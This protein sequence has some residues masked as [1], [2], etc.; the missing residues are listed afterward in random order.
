ML[1][2]IYVGMTGLTGYSRGLRVIA[3]NTTNINTPGFKKS[4]LEF[5]DLFYSNRATGGGNSAYGQLGF[6]L[7]TGATTLSFR[8]GELRQTGNDLDLAIDGQ[9]MFMLRD[10]SGRITY[11]RAGQLEFNSE[12]ILVDRTSGLTVLGFDS[13]GVLGSISID[14]M[15]TR[16]GSATTSVVF[17]GNL[18]SSSTT[19][20]VGNVRVIDSAGGEHVLSARFTNT[21]ATTPGSWNV[22]LLDGTTVVGAAQQIIFASGVP[23]A[24]TSTLNFTYTPPGFTAPM[25]VTLDFS[26]DVTSFAAGTLSTLAMTSQNGFQPGGLTRVSFDASGTLVLT[27]ANGQTTNHGQLAL[28]R[29]DTEDGVVAVGDNQFQAS[30]G[31]GWQTGTAESGSFGAVRGGVVEISNVDLSQ[32]FS[33]LIVMQ[34]GYQASSQIITT[35]NEMLQELFQMKGR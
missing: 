5:K 26:T 4:T 29:F 9:G 21:N 1:E 27:Y 12:G 25:N 10:P 16:A 14:G 18:S 3:N 19:Q 28:A 32:E 20:T 23:T 8:Q 22:E 6:G 7:N 33:D 2:S 30:S 13:N 11:T 35:A 24:A 31:A 17:G 15:R 34:R